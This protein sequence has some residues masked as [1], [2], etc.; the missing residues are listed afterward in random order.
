MMAVVL[1]MMLMLHLE[2]LDNSILLLVVREW[3]QRCLMHL[4]FFQ[5]NVTQAK[6]LTRGRIYTLK[7]PLEVAI[8]HQLCQQ[9]IIRAVELTQHRFSIFQNG[10][11][12]HSVRVS[13]PRP[14]DGLP[15][16]LVRLAGIKKGE[17]SSHEPFWVDALVFQPDYQ[18]LVWGKVLQ[19]L[20]Y[21]QYVQTYRQTTPS[22]HREPVPIMRAPAT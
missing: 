11:A 17:Y 1:M 19:P 14:Q 13:V 8:V 4:L 12:I 22:G 7:L 9:I 5:Q 3:L 16:V 2:M 10:V 18:Q 6:H 21:E 15:C 20:L